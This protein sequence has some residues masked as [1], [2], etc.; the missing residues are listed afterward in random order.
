MSTIHKLGFCDS[1]MNHQDDKNRYRARLE[2]FCQFIS[3][4]L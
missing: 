4:T 3:Q 2:Q 1:N